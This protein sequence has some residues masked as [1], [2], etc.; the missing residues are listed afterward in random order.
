MAGA[1]GARLCVSAGGDAAGFVF[2]AWHLV[3]YYFCVV[4]AAFMALSWLSW[5]TWV[6]VKAVIAV[7]VGVILGAIDLHFVWQVWPLMILR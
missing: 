6:F 7:V 1:G 3:L 5:R 4:G 2:T